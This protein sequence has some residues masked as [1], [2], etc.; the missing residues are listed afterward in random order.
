PPAMM[1]LSTRQYKRSVEDLEILLQFAGG[2][3]AH[4]HDISDLVGYTRGEVP[5]LTAARASIAF[6]D[7]GP[8]IE[9]RPQASESRRLHRLARAL[10]LEDERWQRLTEAM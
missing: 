2:L 3:S 10:G 4:T 5:T 1:M 6:D 7:G 8:R 9:L